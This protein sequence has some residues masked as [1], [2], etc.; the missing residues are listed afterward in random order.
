M[1][2]RR[3]LTKLKPAEPNMTSMIDVVFLLISFFTL[4]M[5]FS[6]AEQNEEIALPK[7]E[8]AQPPDASPPEMITLQIA[9]DRTI[10]VG[11]RA[12]GVENDDYSSTS[13]AAALRDELD[14][15]HLVRRVEPKDVTIVI[16]G[17]SDVEVGYVQRVIGVCQSVGA[18]TFTLRARQ[19]RD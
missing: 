15:L 19:S 3:S 10:F 14:V 8:L 17:D 11:N 18:D 5:N 1:S 16:R 6:Q 9:S 13:L 12:C 2:Q 7:S 4:V